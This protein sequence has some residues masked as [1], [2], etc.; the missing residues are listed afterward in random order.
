[1]P[2]LRLRVRVLLA[3][4]TSTK[5]Q[6]RRRLKLRNMRIARLPRRWLRVKRLL[7]PHI[8]FRRT[9]WLFEFRR[10]QSLTE[11]VRGN[12][13]THGSDCYTKSRRARSTSTEHDEQP[14]PSVAPKSSIGR[15]WL[16]P[17]STPRLSGSQKI[18]HGV[19]ISC[20]CSVKRCSCS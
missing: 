18:C 16:A 1:M 6:G 13:R 11:A 7:V 17:E 14:E 9:R 3:R 4:S 5:S 2:Y 19:R 12:L 20:S 8:G 15:F 10:Y